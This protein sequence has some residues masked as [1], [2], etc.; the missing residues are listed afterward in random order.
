MTGK[1]CRREKFSSSYGIR[2]KQKEKYDGYFEENLE[3]EC[4]GWAGHCDRNDRTDNWSGHLGPG[5]AVPAV[6]ELRI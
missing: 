3:Y 5:K 4:N 6:E 1:K 2:P